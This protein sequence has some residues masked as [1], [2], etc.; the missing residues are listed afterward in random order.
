M[1]SFICPGS[2]NLLLYLDYKPFC[3]MQVENLA[4]C[5]VMQNVILIRKS[6]QKD[7]S[8][9]SPNIN[10]FCMSLVLWMLLQYFLSW[11]HVFAFK[12]NLPVI[13][14]DYGLAHIMKCSCSESAYLLQ[15]GSLQTRH[16]LG[17]GW[18]L[19]GTSGSHLVQAEVGTTRVSCP[20]L[21][22]F[23][24][25]Q[26]WWLQLANHYEEKLVNKRQQ[27]KSI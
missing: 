13:P 21:S 8:H 7:M 15:P 6:L 9:D 24:Y 2:I 3:S 14:L 5:R 18:R 23:K 11:K 25:L 27:N 12:E 26:G 20:R 17:E 16:R 4:V 10:P 19:E 22:A 1:V